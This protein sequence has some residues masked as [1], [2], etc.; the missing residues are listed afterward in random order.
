MSGIVRGCKNSRCGDMYYTR[1]GIYGD[2]CCFECQEARRF[3]DLEEKVE[4]LENKLK[5]IQGQLEYCLDRLKFY[6]LSYI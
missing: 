5:E 3:D 6:G 2:Y 4:E 1:D